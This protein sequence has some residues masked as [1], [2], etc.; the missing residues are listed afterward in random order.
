M[1]NKYVL[2]VQGNKIDIQD[3]QV[4][5]RDMYHN[6]VRHKQEFGHLYFFGMRKNWFPLVLL[7]KYTVRHGQKAL[8]E[9]IAIGVLFM[10][11]LNDA[12][13][14]SFY[15]DK[16]EVVKPNSIIRIHYRAKHN[17][18]M[19][20]HRIMTLF[21]LKYKQLMYI[22]PLLTQKIALLQTLPCTLLISLIYVNTTTY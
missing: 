11:L 17:Q 7:D 2:T 15:L 21:N 18:K 12:N 3:L 13:S 4:G 6:K 19:A 16:Y 10:S 22:I 20:I 8:E 5:I 14:Y 9:R 1:L